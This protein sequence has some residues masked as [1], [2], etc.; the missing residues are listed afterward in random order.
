MLV[1]VMYIFFKNLSSIIMITAIVWNDN[2]TSIFIIPEQL[3]LSM[4]ISLINSSHDT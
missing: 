1:I 2:V 3:L 4:Y